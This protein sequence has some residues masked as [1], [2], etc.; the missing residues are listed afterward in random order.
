MPHT[1]LIPFE[2]QANPRQCGAAA[3]S[4]VYRSL[5]LEVSQ[6]DIWPALLSP[7]GKENGARTHRLAAD[8]RHRNLAGLVVQARDP[9]QFLQICRTH[10]ARAI[11]N[12]RSAIHAWTGHYSVLV[13]QTAE[14]VIVHDPHFGPNRRLRREELLHLWR[15]SAA[16]Q[17]EISGNVVVAVAHNTDEESHLCDV[18]HAEVPAEIACPGCARPILLK[19]AALIGCIDEQC[20]GRTWERLFCPECDRVVRGEAALESAATGLAGV[21][22]GSTPLANGVGEL[23]AGLEQAIGRAAPGEGRDLMVQIKSRIEELYEEV[24]PHLRQTYAEGKQNLAALQAHVDEL[25]KQAKPPRKPLG[26]RALPPGP[27]QEEIDPALGARVRNRLLHE[28]QKPHAPAPTAADI[29][30]DVWQDLEDPPAARPPMKK[31]RPLSGIR[32]PAAQPPQPVDLQE[33][34]KHFLEEARGALPAPAADPDLPIWE[35]D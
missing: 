21:G 3:L 13:Q 4:M 11:L 35:D 5:G 18:C 34:A 12:H 16:P 22:A 32:S 14:Q 6:A 28:I 24:M 33:K 20:E 10:Q 27:P 29:H 1:N 23:T 17:C 8:A 25:P 9:W 7:K 2:K 19:P 31:F 30:L 26:R 15:R